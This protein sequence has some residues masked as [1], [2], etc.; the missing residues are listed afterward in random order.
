MFSDG[1]ARLFEARVVGIIPPAAL[2]IEPCNILMILHHQLRIFPRPLPPLPPA[3]TLPPPPCGSLHPKNNRRLSQRCTHARI[4]SK[5]LEF[6]P[7]KVTSSGRVRPLGAAMMRW[8]RFTKSKGF[9]RKVVLKLMR[10]CC[11]STHKHIRKR[12]KRTNECP[13]TKDLRRLY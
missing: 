7:E 2:P 1:Q 3:S 4:Y 9:N 11:R 10:T 13:E 12:Y 5:R 8:W 6:E